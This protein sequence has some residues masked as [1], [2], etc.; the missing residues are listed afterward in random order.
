MIL[1]TAYGG[2]IFFDAKFTT[3]MNVQKNRVI[4]LKSRLT[5]TDG[6]ANI[7][8]HSPSITPWR[9][10][11]Y[12][13]N[14]AIQLCSKENISKTFLINEDKRSKRFKLISIPA[15]I[16]HKIYET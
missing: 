12:L 10:Q 5:T 4:I 9:I 14:M 2:F 15:L 13:K 11:N 16:V 7:T 6:T 8:Y 3:F 1:H